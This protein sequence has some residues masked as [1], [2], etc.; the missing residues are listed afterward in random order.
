[1]RTTP[2]LTEII[3]LR[4]PKSYLSRALKSHWN[5]WGQYERE[6]GET[7]NPRS[8]QLVK[9]ARMQR[10]GLRLSN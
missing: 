9:Q 5:A 3:T 8:R 1:M 10:L 2:D 7:R 4:R 6:D